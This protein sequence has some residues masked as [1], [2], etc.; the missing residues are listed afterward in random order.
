MERTPIATTDSFAL[1]INAEWTGHLIFFLLTS[2]LGVMGLVSIFMSPE[3]DFLIVAALAVALPQLWLYRFKIVLGNDKLCYTTL[4]SSKSIVLSNLTN[5]KIEVGIGAGL[6]ARTQPYYRL[7]LYDNAQFLENPLTINMKPFGRS[8]L[9]RVA[10][11]IVANAPS[12][13][14]DKSVVSLSQG[15]IKPATRAALQQIW[16]VAILIFVLFLILGVV[17][18]LLQ[19]TL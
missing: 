2:P 7:N 6:K 4:F 5:A 14:I 16:K 17:R 3:V 10:K 12:A 1:R 8:D 19:N 9:A 11:A 18:A 15:S 13:K